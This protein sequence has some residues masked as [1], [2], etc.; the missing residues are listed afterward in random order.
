[1]EPGAVVRDSILMS[2]TVVKSGAV[3]EYAIVA[4]NVTIGEN[5]VIGK[6]PEDVV[7]KEE[8]GIAVVGSNVT[9]APGATV[10]P[11]QMVDKDVM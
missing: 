8:W 1:M 7:N 10:A 11:K 4:E 5:A 2:G 9:V 3:V 6:R